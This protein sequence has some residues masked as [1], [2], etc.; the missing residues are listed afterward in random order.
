MTARRE[1]LLELIKDKELGGDAAVLR[2][3]I[4]GTGHQRELAVV[5][6]A[7]EI[8]SGVV[9]QVVEDEHFRTGLILGIV[10]ADVQEPSP[11]LS[12]KVCS[13]TALYS[14]ASS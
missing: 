3:E 4:L 9:E 13:P 11:L 8:G 5:V 2:Q 14:A 1:A 7:P 6:V 12:P 10:A